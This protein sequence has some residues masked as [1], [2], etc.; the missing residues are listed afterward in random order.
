MNSALKATSTQS[1]LFIKTKQKDLAM[2][3]E[4]NMARWLTITSLTVSE[5]ACLLSGQD[6]D[7]HDLASS[8]TVLDP[9][10]RSVL[11]WLVRAIDDQLLQA[12]SPSM[13]SRPEEHRIRLEPTLNWLDDNQA[14]F[15]KGH[16][17][18]AAAR[19]AIPAPF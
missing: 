12:Y 3:E 11:R 6:P 13:N 17:F 2:K 15:P 1:V 18:L 10:V 14:A 8:E 5:L 9:E 7:A 16:R 4:I 19:H